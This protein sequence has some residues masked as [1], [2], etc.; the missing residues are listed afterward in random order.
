[1]ATRYKD[2][3]WFRTPPTIVQPI[4]LPPLATLARWLDK[5]R[6]IERYWTSDRILS[7]QAGLGRLPERIRRRTK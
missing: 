1:L 3:V 7:A 5:E 4:L 6:T 2:E